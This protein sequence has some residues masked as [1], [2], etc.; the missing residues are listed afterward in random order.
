MDITQVQRRIRLRDLETLATVVQ[1]GSMRKAAQLMHLSQP[2]ISRSIR[3]L[4]QAVGCELLQRSR[5]GIEPTLFGEALVR[6]GRGVFDELQGA[7]RELAHL[8]DPGAGEVHLACMET[9]HA[10]LVGACVESLLAQHPRIRVVLESGQAPDLIG[11]FLMQRLVDFTVARPS[12]LPLPPGVEGETLFHDVPRVLVGRASPHV[13]R[14]KVRLA[15]LAE[16][17]WVLG[18]TELMAASPVARAFAEAGLA[19][20]ARVT[21]SGSLHTRYRL[22][23]T[24]RCVTVVPHSLLPFANPGDRF[25]VL[26]IEMPAWEFPTM[27]LK[28][29]HRVLSPAA[30]LFID[31]LRRLARPLAVDRPVGSP[32]QQRSSA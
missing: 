12:E 4:E 5:G 1:A 31:E 6:R 25:R 8:A 28:L 32:G 23:D 21:A 7:L 15:D 22:L 14:R 18:R 24:G 26:P 29:Q 10:G 30:H 2:A 19:M 16:D 20:P 11:L 9:L 17:H 13:R 3:D 27:V